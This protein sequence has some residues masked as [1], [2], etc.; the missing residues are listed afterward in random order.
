[1]TGYGVDLQSGAPNTTGFERHDTS[2][3]APQCV[4]NWKAEF[5]GDWERRYALS[6]ALARLLVPCV[7]PK[8]VKSAMGPLMAEA[9]RLW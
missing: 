3:R 2:Y 4:M 5:T 9:L 7:D 6:L 1:M 8:F